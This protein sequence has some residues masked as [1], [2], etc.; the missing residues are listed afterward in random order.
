[1]SNLFDELIEMFS[2]E[3]KNSD[4]KEKVA[5]IIEPL[6]QQIIVI[7]KEQLGHYLQVFGISF[8]IL[9]VVSL[10]NLTL[11]IQHTGSFSSV[12]NVPIPG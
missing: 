6:V 9:L 8:I 3:L 11:L 10:I 4:K 2:T 5:S 1:M 12:S 7:F